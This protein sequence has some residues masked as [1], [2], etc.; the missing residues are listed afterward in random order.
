MR[1]RGDGAECAAGCVRGGGAHRPTETDLAATDNKEFGREAQRAGARR[2]GSQNSGSEQEMS[3]AA[4]TQV[5]L[6][7]GTAERINRV[8]RYI[9]RAQ[10]CSKIYGCEPFNRAEKLGKVRLRLCTERET[11]LVLRSTG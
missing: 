4:R 2:R 10:G 5:G 9:W 3:T 11:L 6:G 8:R 1:R 7:T